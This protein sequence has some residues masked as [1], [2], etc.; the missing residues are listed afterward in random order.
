MKKIVLTLVAALTI[1]ASGFAME[2][3]KEEVLQA[4]NAKFPGAKEVSWTTGGS[5]YYKA[6]FL[7]YGTHM[8]AWYETNGKFISVTRNMSSTELPL[9][10][11]NS[12]KVNY[13]NYWITDVVEESNKN[14]FT[15]YITLEN[16]D[17]KITLVSK[18]GSNWEVYEKHEKV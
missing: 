18:K 14:G 3:V 2:E 15:Y 5:N 6:S 17:Y 16:A 4:F 7:F 8:V 9:Y 1:I 10:L 13:G 12:I 11:R